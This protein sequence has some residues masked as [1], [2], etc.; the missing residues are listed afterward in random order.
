ME[1]GLYI[2][3][4][5]ADARCFLAMCRFPRRWLLHNRVYGCIGRAGQ[6]EC[7]LYPHLDWLEAAHHN[8][9]SQASAM[10]L[11]RQSLQPPEPCAFRPYAAIRRVMHQPLSR[12][13][14]CR[15]KRVDHI[16]TSRQKARKVSL[17]L[18]TSS[19]RHIYAPKSMTT[20]N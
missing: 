8:R 2:E 9:I 15:G 7:T 18:Q 4:C 20:R 13:S 3:A 6:S 12:F 16:D 17:S 5:R 1:T 11:H 19:V 14:T 10:K